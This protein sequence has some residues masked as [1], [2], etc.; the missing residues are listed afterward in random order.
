MSDAEGPDPFAPASLGPVRLRN[1]IVKAATFEGLTREHVVTDALIDFHRA[2][3]AGGVGMTTLAYCAV[4]P[5]GCGTPNEL[6]P[7]AR[8]RPRAW[9]GLA[10]AVHAEGAAVSAQLGHAGAVAAGTG[11]QGPV[12][13]AG[14]QPAGDAAHQ[15]RHRR[16]HRAASSTTSPPPPGVVADAGFDAV[17]VHLGHGYLLSEFLSPRLN[18][19]TDEWGGVAREPGPLPPG[20]RARPCARR[21]ATAWPCW[22]S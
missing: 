17:E 21:S 18:K 13:V 11:L 15:G 10:D 1:R 5:D 19:R 7:H 9:P 20:D 8:G 14:V 22:P 12:A 3:A 2:V 4:S 6:D 16:R